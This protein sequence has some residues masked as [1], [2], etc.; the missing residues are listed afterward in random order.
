MVRSAPLAVRRT[1][2]L[3][4]RHRAGYCE[5]KSHPKAQTTDRFKKMRDKRSKKMGWTLTVNTDSKML[6]FTG[7]SKKTTG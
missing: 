6:F 5:Q 3:N 2:P 1:E 4:A 7:L